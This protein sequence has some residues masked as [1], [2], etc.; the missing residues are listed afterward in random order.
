MC[1][2]DRSA[3]TDNLDGETTT[4]FTKKVKAKYTLTGPQSQVYTSMKRV[5]GPKGKVRI[6]GVKDIPGDRGYVAQNF[7]IGTIFLRAEQGEKLGVYS[8]GPMGSPMLI[9]D[10]RREN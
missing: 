5:V 4:V 8:V 7:D 10:S 2:R 9:Y 6:I 3:T 1:I